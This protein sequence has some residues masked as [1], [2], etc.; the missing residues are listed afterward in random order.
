VKK[1]KILI[2]E[3][4]PA[5]AELALREIDKAGIVY[6]QRRVANEADYRHELGEFKPDIILSD[7][8]LP[9]FNGLSALSIA[10]TVCPETPFIFVSGTIGE[11]QAIDAIRR[12]A[13]DYV[14]K[15]NLAR[16]VPTVRRAI[17]EADDRATRRRTE[18]I[19]EH[20][21]KKYESLVNTIEG[22]V[23]EVELLDF[24]FSFVSE[25]AERVLGYPLRAWLDESNFWKDHIHPD[26]RDRAIA[27]RQQQTSAMRAHQF[28]YRML[29]ADGRTVWM[30]DYVSV[31]V[32]NGRP[33]KLQGVMVDITEPKLQEQKIDRLN[34]VYAVLSG[35]N[36]TIV[37]VKDRQELFSE[38][39]RIVVTDGGFRRAAICMVDEATGKILPVAS[40]GEDVQPLVQMNISEPD[41]DA[42]DE[43]SVA[44]EALR[45]RSPVVFNDI[46]AVSNPTF[47]SS[48]LA[49]RLRSFAVLPLIVE[50]IALGV[51]VLYASE[52][53]FFDQKEMKLLNELAADIS[54]AL[55]HIDKRERLEYLAYF[56]ALTGLPNRTLFYDRLS[57]S[58][59]TAT[60]E[61]KKAALI[62]V[63]LVNFKLINDSLG[64]YAGDAVLREFATRLQD[65]LP[66]EITIA[67]VTGDVFAI[68]HAGVGDFVDIA[69]P[70][71]EKILGACEPVIKVEGQEV[72]V[73]VKLG[74]AVFPGDGVN[75]DT[76][77]KNAEAALK[78]AKKSIEASV[79]Y[80]PEMNARVSESLALR[81][82][83]RR[84]ID[85]ERFVLYFQPIHEIGSGRICGAE[86]LVRWNDPETGLVPPMQFIPLLEETGMILDL[87]RWVLEKAMA[88]HAQWRTAGLEPP[89]ISVNVSAIQLRHKGFVKE[90]TKAV[91]NSGNH[92]LDLEITE[93][94]MM[95]DVERNVTKIQ[96]IRDMGLEVAIDD[97]GTGYSSLSYLSKLPI[98]ALKID[99]AFIMNLSE[100]PNSMTLVSTI[101]SLAHALNLKVVAEGVETESQ[102]NLLK[103]LRCDMMQGFLFNRPLPADEFTTLLARPVHAVIN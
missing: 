26:D 77:F 83:L 31:V 2:V 11:E 87:G 64:Q 22:I 89:R 8:T 17:L 94:V 95:E 14:L 103:L 46:G 102:S 20:T 72:R 4:V 12:G 10:K 86:A 100:N 90:M 81:N 35:I 44:A 56:D 23:W 54:F 73:Y 74:I 85:E 92:G 7:F 60:A 52:A 71:V 82:K 69:R 101:I 78:K 6:V 49:N 5:D 25:Q 59:Q 13:T 80:S 88:L 68:A 63:D 55:E 29:A 33:V 98:N 48:A 96:S 47:K 21:R 15:S 3:D 62:L 76:L 61:N 19:A 67:R 42:P 50:G 99:R 79:Y 45:T 51:L 57:Q 24:R 40:M 38:T 93:S 97:F 65:F 84:A 1:I 39:C 27:Y 18:E 30:R 43:E 58:L 36:G 34:R 41:A 28:D 75:T 32:E 53:D 16:L 66:G 9:G 70:L 91:G 37:R